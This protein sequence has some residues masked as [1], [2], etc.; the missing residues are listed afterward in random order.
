MFPSRGS[1]PA[2]ACIVEDRSS[3]RAEKALS[4]KGGSAGTSIDIIAQGF[5]LANRRISEGV[6]YEA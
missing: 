4:Q 3:L 5:R 1:V 6:T 2:E